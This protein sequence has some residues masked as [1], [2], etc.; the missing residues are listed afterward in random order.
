M[1]KL[2]NIIL[3][4]NDEIIPLPALKDKNIDY[5]ALGHI[6]SYELNRLDSRGE[7]AYSGCLEGRGFDECGDKGFVVLDIVDNKVEYEFMPFAS[8]KLFEIEFDISNYLDWFEIEREMF[9]RL[10]D[11]DSSS[12]VKIIIV[13]KFTLNM[14]KHISLC[15]KKL[16]EKFYFAKIKDNS[17]LKLNDLD[18]MNDYSLR[19]EY[20]RQVMD[21]N[22]SKDE[23]DQLILMG[24]KALDGEELC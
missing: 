3:E 16:C 14:Q 6:H 2:V 23:K 22:L 5:L 9:A 19:G 21:S 12:M 17:T 1:D 15:E 8:R 24:V 11:V 10:E 13:G 7:Y 4:K 20:I 18:Y